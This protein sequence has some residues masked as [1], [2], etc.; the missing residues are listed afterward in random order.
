MNNTNLKIKTTSQAF[1]AEMGGLSQVFEEFKNN[2]AT[3]NKIASNSAAFLSE[4]QKI[5]LALKKRIE[6]ENKDLYP[7]LFQ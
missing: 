4:S 2:F 3:T 6:K 1:Y 7:L 5:F